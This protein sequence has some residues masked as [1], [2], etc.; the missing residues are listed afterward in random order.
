MQN[1]AFLLILMEHIYPPPHIHSAAP[2]RGRARGLP[3]PTAPRG[4]RL[5][6]HPQGCGVGGSGPTPVP[7]LHSWTDFGD[8]AQPGAGKVC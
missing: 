3:S 4:P 2:P 5:S 7:V 6:A 8:P 1:G